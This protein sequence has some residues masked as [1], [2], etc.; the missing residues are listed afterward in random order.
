[1]SA[2][3]ER[4]DPVLIVQADPVTVDRDTAA[5]LLDV[6]VAHFRRHISHQ[7]PS[8]KSGAKVLYTMKG[9]RAWAEREAL[10]GGRRTA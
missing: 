7:V 8:I 6:S 10:V 1:V 5:A 2:V 9:L 3:V 4:L